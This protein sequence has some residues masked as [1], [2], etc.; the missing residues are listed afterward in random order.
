VHFY[1]R[2]K[3]VVEGEPDHSSV[4]EGQKYDLKARRVED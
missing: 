1:D 2:S 3:P 4:A